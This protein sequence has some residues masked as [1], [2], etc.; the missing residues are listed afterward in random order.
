MLNTG[1]GVYVLKT[2]LLTVKCE[3]VAFIFIYI[4]VYARVVF[5]DRVSFVR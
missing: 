4:H 1:E 5:H 3:Q 2:V